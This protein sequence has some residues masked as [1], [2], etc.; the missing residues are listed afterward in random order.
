MSSL[1]T[2]LARDVSL[3]PIPVPLIREPACRHPG[4]AYRPGYPGSWMIR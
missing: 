3:Q 1:S 4:E 2:R